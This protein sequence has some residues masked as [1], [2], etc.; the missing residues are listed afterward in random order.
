MPPEGRARLPMIGPKRFN[1]THKAWLPIPSHRDSR[2][3][4]AVFS[5][6]AR[7]R[8]EN[9]ARLGRHDDTAGD[10]QW[11]VITSKLGR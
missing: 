8:V 10:G 1:P 7:A 9:D 4:R 3:Y 2:H 11:T 6:T 5:N